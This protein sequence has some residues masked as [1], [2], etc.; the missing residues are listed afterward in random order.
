MNDK[1]RTGLLIP[2]KPAN[3]I[4]TKPHACKLPT[5]WRWLKDLCSGQIYRSGTMFRCPT[6]LKFW[7]YLAFGS[8]MSTIDRHGFREW[9]DAGGYITKN[10]Q[11]YL[12][13]LRKYGLDN[14][15]V[16]VRLEAYNNNLIE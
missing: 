15:P 6:C 10:E 9:V 14:L 8:W 13:Q 7:S 2:P 16:D 11:T 12:E 4:I 1:I 5:F 3:I